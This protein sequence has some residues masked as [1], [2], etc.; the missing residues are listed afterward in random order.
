MI[1]FQDGDYRARL[2]LDPQ[3]LEYYAGKDNQS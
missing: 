3:A 1:T 2:E